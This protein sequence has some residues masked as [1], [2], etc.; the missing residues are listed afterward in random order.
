[1]G[2]CHVVILIFDMQ[3]PGK[4]NLC[5]KTLASDFPYA[6][7]EHLLRAIHSIAHAAHECL[8]QYRHSNGCLYNT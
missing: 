1:M 6:F 5:C 2:N 8:N 7:V 4:H 3:V